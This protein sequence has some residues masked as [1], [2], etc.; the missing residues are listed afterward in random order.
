MTILSCIFFFFF[1]CGGCFQDSELQGYIRVE[2]MFSIA[3]SEDEASRD[4]KY[5]HSFEVNTRGRGY[6]F[7]ADSAEELD[8]WVATFEKIINS[9]A[10]DN[11]VSFYI[12]NVHRYETLF[13]RT[14]CVM[15]EASL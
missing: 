1:F 15:K 2:E 4:P 3:R 12:T 14:Q 8:D 6:L 10:A 9:D 13:T 5:K 7:S 11:L